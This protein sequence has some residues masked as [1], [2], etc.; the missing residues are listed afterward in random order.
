VERVIPTHRRNA[1]TTSPFSENDLYAEHFLRTSLTIIR[2]RILR[3]AKDAPES[4]RKQR[5][6]EED[7]IERPEVGG[8]HHHYERRAA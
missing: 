2:A 4:R 5:E 1:W 3:K 7:V 6:Q 8:L